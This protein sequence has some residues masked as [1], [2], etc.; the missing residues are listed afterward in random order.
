MSSLGTRHF[1]W[2][3]SCRGSNILAMGLYYFHHNG[4]LNHAMLT[5]SYKAF[6]GDDDTD[7][8]LLPTRV[9]ELDGLGTLTR[10]ITNLTSSYKFICAHLGQVKYFPKK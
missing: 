1:V 10:A 5:R 9:G 7:E 8:L 6:K 3:L 4:S 2:V